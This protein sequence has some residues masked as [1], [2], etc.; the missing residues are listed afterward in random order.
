MRS[1]SR[2]SDLLKILRWGLLVFIAPVLLI[3]QLAEQ[4]NFHGD[5]LYMESLYEHLL[6]RGLGLGT[7]TFTQTSFLFPDALVYFPI[8]MLTAGYDPRVAIMIYA[9]LMMLSFVGLVDL[10]LKHLH[11]DSSRLQRLEVSVSFLVLS[12]FSGVFFRFFFWPAHHGVLILFAL[13]ILVVYLN[14]DLERKVSPWVIAALYT[15]SCLLSFSDLLMIPQVLLPFVFVFVYR[16]IH[17]RQRVSPAECYVVTSLVIG[18]AQGYLLVKLAASFEWFQFT[19]KPLTISFSNFIRCTYQFLNDVPLIVNQSL[20]G[21]LLIV[22]LLFLLRALRLNRDQSPTSNHLLFAALSCGFL[23]FLASVFSAGQ[24]H[25]Y[26][27]VRYIQNLWMLPIVF[28][29]VVCLKTNVFGMPLRR[30]LQLVVITF[31]L[32]NFSGVLEPESKRALVKHYNSVLSC[33]EG[34]SDRLPNRYGLSDFWMS[35]VVHFSSTQGLEV[36]QVIEGNKVYKWMNS[37]EW[38]KR[39][40]RGVEIPHFSYVI[41][42]NE[43]MK[44]DVEREFGAPAETLPCEGSETLHVLLY[45]EG[46]YLRRSLKRITPA[47]RLAKHP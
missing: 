19:H 40:R 12:S 35:R 36:M 3:Q 4:G 14:L 22:A 46:L 34:Y 42:I 26:F 10:V 1:K 21:A 41:T 13:L 44:Q 28:V 27:K 5:L 33:I 15:F 39:N 18:A 37:T 31:M 29:G 6:I 2:F 16:W 47:V 30:L 8:R 9:G 17:Q 25:N 7:Y 24:W 38:Y 43:K 23:I 20:C 11:S 45:P 32:F